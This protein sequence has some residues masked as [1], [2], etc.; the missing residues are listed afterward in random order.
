MYVSVYKK[1]SSASPD[2][3]PRGVWGCPHLFKLQY[4]S[5]TNIHW[6]G[7]LLRLVI[8]LL[9]LLF[10]DNWLFYCVKIGDENKTFLKAKAF[11]YF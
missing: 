1:A 2:S 4:A 6:Q 9:C 11:I 10:T 3:M 8:L 7:G 5:A